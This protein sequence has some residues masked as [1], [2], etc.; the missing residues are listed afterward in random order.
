LTS[1]KF[2]IVASVTPAFAHAPI[3]GIGAFYNGILHP[4]LVPSHL[5]LFI[6]VGLLLGQQSQ[7]LRANAWYAFVGSFWA[8]LALG[9]AV[10]LTVPQ[11]VLLAL[12]LITG[13]CVALG[14][15]LRALLLVI[16]TALCGV[17]VG[18]DSRAETFEQRDIWVAIIGT[19]IGGALIL[20]LVGGFAAA[21]PRPWQRIGIR[22]AG[23]WIAAGAAI[24]FVLTMAQPKSAG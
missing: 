1:R 15:S 9:Q 21:L 11:A 13:G 23:S 3:E 18:M 14:R 20:S 16:L 5:I 2:Q 7:P 19:A 24:A 12:A 4:L 10:G 22:V 17:G 6:G 8:G